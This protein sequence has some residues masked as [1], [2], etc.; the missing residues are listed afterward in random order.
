M[1]IIAL[2]LST[3]IQAVCDQKPGI[4]LDPGG[5]V[6]VQWIKLGMVVERGVPGCIWTR[7]A[8]L[9]DTSYATVTEKGG[10]ET[11]MNN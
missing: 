5:G 7:I 4:P 9:F 3:Q 2:Q 1:L 10:G 8:L 6:G 11:E